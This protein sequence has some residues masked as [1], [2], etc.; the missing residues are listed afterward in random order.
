MKVLGTGEAARQVADT[1][2]L[3]L[4]LEAQPEEKYVAVLQGEDA[5]VHYESLTEAG[6]T[7]LA[8]VAWCVPSAVLARLAPGSPPLVVGCPDAWGLQA[9]LERGNDQETVAR[10]ERLARAEAH[11]AGGVGA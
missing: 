9:A 6:V 3:E 11:L 8:L 4:D 7:P 5:L 1:L 2:G 10:L